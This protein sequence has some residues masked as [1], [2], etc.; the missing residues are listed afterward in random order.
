MSVKYCPYATQK[1]LYIF[2]FKASKALKSTLC[3]G[4]LFTILSNNTIY[5]YNSLLAIATRQAA[6]LIKDIKDIKDKLG[7]IYKAYSK[8]I[9]DKINKV[10]KTKLLEL[11]AE[12]IIK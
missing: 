3:L 2:S 11:L 12:K 5:I 7:A 8:T 6:I 9:K 10:N 4:V 1:I